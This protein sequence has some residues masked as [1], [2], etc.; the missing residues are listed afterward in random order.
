MPSK[1]EP[2]TRREPT[3]DFLFASSPFLPSSARVG[4]T[5]TVRCFQQRTETRRNWLQMRYCATKCTLTC[6]DC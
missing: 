4:E 6:K 3:N 5:T 2:A 1:S